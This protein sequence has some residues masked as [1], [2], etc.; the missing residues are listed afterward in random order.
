[1]IGTKTRWPNVQ[2]LA[3]FGRVFDFKHPFSTRDQLELIPCAMG[4]EV[5]EEA[6]MAVVRRRG[7]CFGPTM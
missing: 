1:M 2:R 3:S 4:I 7:S 5:D 6:V